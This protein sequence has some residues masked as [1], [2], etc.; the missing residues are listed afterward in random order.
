MRIYWINTFEKGNIG[1][2]ARP[3]GNDWLEGEIQKLSISGVNM[4]V[5]LLE[6]HEEVEL[7]IEKENELCQ[8]Q[9]IGYIN[10]PIKD[11][12][13]PEDVD[14]FLQLISTID[15]SLRNDKKIVIHCRMGIGRTSMVTAGA[16]IKNGHEP[17]SV[18]DF[19]SEKRTLSVPDTDEQIEWIKG[20]KYAL[21]Q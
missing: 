14:S 8:K 20:Q 11:R 9:N 6:K 16:L 17:E 5:S 3:R 19:L 15:Q 4:V 2:M 18:F 13:V 10:F 7:D 21:Q 12:G 1:M